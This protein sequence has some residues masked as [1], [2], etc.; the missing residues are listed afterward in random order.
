MTSGHNVL[1][2]LA[3]ILV[4]VAGLGFAARSGIR[5]FFYPTAPPMPGD[6]SEPT[7]AILARLDSVLQEKAPGAL[8]Q[9]RPGLTS[10]EIAQLEDEN[11]VRLPDD[12]KVIY[13]WHDGSWQT[14]NDSSELI[15]GHRFWPLREAIEERRAIRKQAAE[16]SLAGRLAFRVFASHTASWIGLFTDG[17]GDGYFYDP[18][19]TAAEGAVFNHFA[20][21][22]TYVFFPSAT[23]LMAG[24][25][26]CWAE[27]V[28]PEPAHASHSDLAD[29]LTRE[30]RV[31][32]E[33]GARVNE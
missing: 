17:A 3:A 28:Y 33:F 29:R 6:V 20:E 16:A 31:W 9:L 32:S 27:N 12:I 8:A 24:V 26:K 10:A 7:A 4:L 2:R 5:R 19:R 21:T 1:I 11:G 15:P 18:A 14:T 25:A 13:R 22:R 23:N 30:D